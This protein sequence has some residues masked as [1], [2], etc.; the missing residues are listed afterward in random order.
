M[1]ALLIRWQTCFA[2]PAG[3]LATCGRSTLATLRHATLAASVTA[4]LVASALVP[5]P[6]YAEDLPPSADVTGAVNAVDVL[7]AAQPTF[8]DAPI[9]SDLVSDTPDTPPVG[10]PDGWAPGREASGWPRLRGSVDVAAGMVVVQG[11]GLQ[12]AGW[13]VNLDDPHPG[14]VAEVE[15][16]DGDPAAGTLLGKTTVGKARP[17]VARALADPALEASGFEV[18]VPT[19]GMAPGPRTLTVLARTR[20]NGWWWRTA[21]IV[22]AA[23][24]LRPSGQF[25]YGAVLANPETT[26]RQARAAGLTHMSAYVPWKHIEPS[27]GDFVF[28]RMMPWGQPAANDL[29]NVLNAARDAGLKLV[30]RLDEPPD[31]AGGKLYRLDPSDVENYVYEVVS[32]GKGTIAF[33]EVFNEPNL[34]FEWGTSP[35]DPAGYVKILAGAYRGAK[36][37]D[38]SVQVVAAAVAQRTG[39]GGGSMEDVD[40]IDGLYRAGAKD[41]F[42]VMGMHAYLGNFAPDTAPTCVPMCFRTIELHRAVMEAHGDSAKQVLITEVGAL[43]QTA[44]PLDAYEWMKLPADQRA[45]YL[46][47]ALRLANTTYPWIAGAMLFN[48]DFATVPWVPPT[49]AM[50]WF[51]LL[52]PDRS[53]RPAYDRLK[54][55]RASGALP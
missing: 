18:I 5:A 21:S 32:Y 29:T 11:S 51:S 48:L 15:V 26:A 22:V 17:D 24:A 25:I 36:R 28:K 42:D 47:G 45:D 6:S 46:I 10:G 8:M 38:P 12:V 31:W 39:G 3:H 16:Y 41:Y 53:P 34:P 14:A 23:P 2:V 37:A 1:E 13:M 4:V 19:A 54:D 49:S 40:W 43:E 52:N 44:Q 30:F 33:V 20:S 9:V 27:R 50:H 55:A 7:D 35:V